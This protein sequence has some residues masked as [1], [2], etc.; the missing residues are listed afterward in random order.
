MIINVLM[1]FINS[2][3]AKAIA[4]MTCNLQLYSCLSQVGSWSTCL[5]NESRCTLHHSSTLNA[6]QVTRNSYTISPLHSIS[7]AS[8]SL[9]YPSSLR[10]CNI[11]KRSALV[12][13]LRTSF[14]NHI[15]SNLHQQ[16]RWRSEWRLITPR[17]KWSWLS[18]K[19]SSLTVRSKSGSN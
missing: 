14:S 3:T 18:L 7:A 15:S 5:S 2:D 19:W 8:K 17:C 6:Y 10:S 13:L 12:L 1:R 9:M 16:A 11:F 4:S